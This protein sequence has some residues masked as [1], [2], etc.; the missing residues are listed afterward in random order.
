VTNNTFLLNLNNKQGKVLH[1]EYS[2]DLR[3]EIRECDNLRWMHFGGDAIQSVMDIN[4]PSEPQQAYSIAML[5]TM[6][7]LEQPKNVLIMGLGCGTFERL[8]MACMP[9]LV[10][11][12]IESNPAVIRLAK[13][14]FMIPE[15]YPVINATA[16]HFIATNRPVYNMVYCDIFNRQHHPVCL[17]DDEFYRNIFQR[18]STNGVLVVNLLPGSESELLNC[19]LAARKYFEWGY[20]L[21]FPDHRNILLFFLKQNPP[22]LA[23]LDQQATLLSEKLKMDLADIPARFTKLPNK[24]ND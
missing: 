1:A 16:E 12:S 4:Q 15:E 18:L 7:F 21:D 11:T 20:L 2:E 24:H 9:E 6:L 22:K 3:I 5:A 19:L 13:R 17:F 10:I 8:F 23:K 14:F